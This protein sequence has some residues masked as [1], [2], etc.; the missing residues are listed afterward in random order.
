M[1]GVDL[2]LDEVVALYLDAV[3][4]ET[5]PQSIPETSA[6]LGVESVSDRVEL[7]STLDDM[8]SRGLVVERTVGQADAGRRRLS[9]ELTPDGRSLAASVR[10]RVADE[11]V[12]VRRAAGGG[13]QVPVGDLD[14][15][16][17]APALPR[18][19]A[20]ATDDG[21][22]YLG[23]GV[24]RGPVD[25]ESERATLAEVLDAVT[26]GE[27]R[28]VLVSGPAGVGKTT[29]A[30]EL[31]ADLA[32]DRDCRVLIGGCQAAAGRPYGPIKRALADSLASAGASP[33]DRAEPDP[34][35]ADAY[36]AQRVAL[37]RDVASALGPLGRD[38]PTVLVV[39]DL[40][41][42]AAPT[43]ALFEHLAR[44][45]DDG[46]LVV[47]TVRDGGPGG[48]D[49]GD[50]PS[51]LDQWDEA[52][53]GPHLALAPF[54]RADTERLITA[55]VGRPDVPEAF[56][57]AVYERTAGNPLFV[58]ETLEHALD[59]G[60]VDPAHDV[61]PDD[62]AAIEPTGRVSAA[63]ERRVD[64]LDEPTR[65][66]LE[67]GAVVGETVSL[68]VLTDVVDRPEAQTNARVDALVEGGVW[69]RDGESVRFR[70]GLLRE[71]VVDRLDESRLA[72]L[73]AAV[74]DAAADGGA[75]GGTVA[76]HR[77]AAGQ[78]EP[79][80]EALLEAA[81]DARDEYAHE[82]ALKNYESALEVGRDRLGYDED[83]DAVVDVLER[84]AEVYYRLGEYEEADKYYGYVAE[85]TSDPEAGRRIARIRADMLDTFGLVERAQ[86]VAE[87]A[88]EAYGVADTRESGMLLGRRGT[89]LVKLR[90]HESAREDFER[91]RAIG[92]RTGDV[93]LRAVA[94]MNLGGLELNR[95]AADADTVSTLERAV[96]LAED[97]SD[98]RTLA[99][100]ANN[101]AMAHMQTGDLDAAERVFERCLSVR[102]SLGDRMALVRARRN[103]AVIYRAK[104][105]FRA[106]LSTL[107]EAV[108]V[109]ERADNDV[110]L[111][112]CHE[113]IAEIHHAL[114]NLDRAVE[115]REATL[116]AVRRMGQEQFVVSRTAA[117]AATHLDRGDVDEARDLARAA[118]EQ[119][120]ELG[121]PVSLSRALEVRGDVAL[122]DGDVDAAADHYEA[123]LA[124]TADSDVPATAG[125][126]CG[127][128]CGL[129]TVACRREAPTTAAE[130]VEAAEA[131][132]DPDDDPRRVTDVATVRAL[133]ARTRGDEDAALA[134]VDDALAAARSGATQSRVGE[135]AALLE[136]A[137]IERRRGD[138]AAVTDLLAEADSLVDEYGIGRYAGAVA[139]IEESDATT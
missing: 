29:L 9:Y 139:A 16:F 13:E 91:L 101:L 50:R 44:N 103:L 3:D 23:D 79:A 134:A 46:V 109:A 24:D 98:E 128:H 19:L 84:I 118:H 104:G 131:A 6:A 20:R 99:R 92:R 28:A 119:G 108:D 60:T 125:M 72:A 86:D 81:D 73:H 21:V 56:V 71:V 129:A 138:R 105:S 33:F 124:L 106:A 117:L 14:D 35:D 126:E 1:V 97:V 34:E 127:L 116:A 8:A 43:L 36:L 74:A 18:A 25:R 78:Y 77:L 88:V 93:K 67:V 137:R 51:L 55:T 41:L 96:D 47:G 5:T 120:E 95:R 27:G 130:H 82:L 113:D 76:T 136:R 38:R 135:V 102:E 94:A 49:D 59:A 2:D 66:V 87:D 132:L 4:A 64:A 70:S 48:A 45:A 7:L 62:P 31:L 26:A 11:S 75:P 37:F 114:G 39:E 123:G 57:E 68:S 89:E 10:D 122:F 22:V 100:A 83:D 42:A 61:Y 112:A 65:T 32:A 40:H 133:V 12:E 111:A 69:A 107:R 63:V 90:E 54:D 52:V 15:H 53:G 80:Y 115:H 110:L 30:T 121:D 85:R 17:E 58:V